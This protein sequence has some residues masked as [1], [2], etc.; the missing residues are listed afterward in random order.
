MQSPILDYLQ[1]L[2]ERL[3]G[4]SHGQLPTYIPELTRADPEWFGICIVTRDGFVYEVG[5]SGQH[6]TIQ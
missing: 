6:F 4:L 1:G 2:L 5:D 3:R